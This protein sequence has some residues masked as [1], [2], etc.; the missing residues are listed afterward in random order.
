MADRGR[1]RKQGLGN[2]Q[3]LARPRC[4]RR[5]VRISRQSTTTDL[6]QQRW[7]SRMYNGLSRTQCHIRIPPTTSGQAFITAHMACPLPPQTNLQGDLLASRLY[8]EQ[9]T[10]MRPMT[11]GRL[12]KIVVYRLRQMVGWATMMTSTERP[13]SRR[14]RHRQSGNKSHRSCKN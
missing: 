10:T 1:C 2:V 11:H 4:N 7:L 13:K 8:R 14:E 3:H 9:I 6:R 5:N 12:F